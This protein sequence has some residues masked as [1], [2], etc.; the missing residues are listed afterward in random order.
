MSLAG[1]ERHDQRVAQTAILTLVHLI[2]KADPECGE[3][4]VVAL[5][6][7]VWSNESEVTLAHLFT[8]ALEGALGK[9]MGT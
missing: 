4:L 7:T 2:A 6:D 9:R 5:R 1:R 8:E 3:R